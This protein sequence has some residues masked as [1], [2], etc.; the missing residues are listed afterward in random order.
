VLLIVLALAACGSM[1]SSSL[2]CHVR[3]LVDGVVTPDAA[4]TS[5][6]L[7]AVAVANPKGTI[8]V[9]GYTSKIRPPTSYTN[10]LK[11]Y[12]MRAYGDKGSASLYEEDHLVALEDGGNPTDPHNLWPEPYA[13]SGG[14]HA[15]DLVENLLHRLI[16]AG[17]LTIARAAVVLAGDWK[18]TP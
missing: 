6:A 5:G 4:C 7:N 18:A 16:C 14:A 2:A 17:R 12:Q 1:R 8:C 15:K 13:G 11:L 3:T 9:S 10:S